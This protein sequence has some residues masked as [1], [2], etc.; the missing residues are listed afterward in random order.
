MCI[1]FLNPV[2][3]F[4]FG[5]VYHMFF[6]TSASYLFSRRSVYGVCFKNKL[7]CFNM[8]AGSFNFHILSF[9]LSDA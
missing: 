5:L 7:K 2:L 8:H 4:L 9:H 3:E 1:Y 6:H